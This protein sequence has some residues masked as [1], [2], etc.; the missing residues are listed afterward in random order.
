MKTEVALLYSMVII[1]LCLT[2]CSTQ[3]SPAISGDDFAVKR[4]FGNST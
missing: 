1:P 3:A 4:G 2:S